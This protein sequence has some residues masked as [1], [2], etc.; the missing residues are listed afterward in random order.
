MGVERSPLDPP[1]S[2]GSSPVVFYSNAIKLYSTM[3]SSIRAVH[4]ILSM[5]LLTARRVIALHAAGSFKTLVDPLFSCD[6]RD[7][8]LTQLFHSLR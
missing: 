2:P 7:R 6:K 1:S 4:P 8:L 5:E 3:T